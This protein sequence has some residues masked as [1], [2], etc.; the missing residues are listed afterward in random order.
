MYTMHF[1]GH[2]K[3]INELMSFAVFIWNF[4]K[5]KSLKFE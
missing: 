4:D 5:Y 3:N 1:I 2:S